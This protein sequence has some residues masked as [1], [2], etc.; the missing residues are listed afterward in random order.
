MKADPLID[1]LSSYLARNPG[2]RLTQTEIIE[3]FDTTRPT[4]K[5]AWR[6]LQDEG[7]V[8]IEPVMMASGAE[9]AA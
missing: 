4:V 1:K 3:K 9:V 6:Q 7:L 5:R 2:A 8:L